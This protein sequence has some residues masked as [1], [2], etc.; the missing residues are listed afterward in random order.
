VRLSRYV[1]VIES[2]AAAGTASA[3]RASDQAAL[4]DIRTSDLTEKQWMI[5]GQRTAMNCIARL[6]KTPHDCKRRTSET[7]GLASALPKAK[8]AALVP[9][10]GTS[11]RS[12]PSRA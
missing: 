4:Y 6:G 8:S 12:V 5:G 3:R 10:G 2:A 1:P 11:N 7:Y 9:L